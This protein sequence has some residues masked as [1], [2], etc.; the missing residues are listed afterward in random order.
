MRTN[1]KIKT[2]LA[3]E[4]S[5]RRIVKPEHEA[6]WDRFAAFL[7]A[8][9]ALGALLGRFWAFLGRSEGALGTSLGAFGLLSGQSWGILDVLRCSWGDRGALL[10]R[11][12]DK[13]DL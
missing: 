8:L 9:G 5:L 4:G 6:L 13:F 11:F 2:K 12:P 10:G 7:G 1:I 3:R